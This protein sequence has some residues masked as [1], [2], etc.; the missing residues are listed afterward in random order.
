[1]LERGR[2]GPKVA[3]SSPHT[4]IHSQQ[5]T[6]REKGRKGQ[7]GIKADQPQERNAQANVCCCVT[8]KSR[9]SSS[10]RMY[11]LSSRF[12]SARSVVL[13]FLTVMVSHD[14]PTYGNAPN[15]AESPGEPTAVRRILH[16]SRG[17]EI[18]NNRR[19]RTEARTRG[20][21]VSPS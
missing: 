3:S 4:T 10:M 2:G 5:P 13:P 7:A 19:Q 6:N 12:W 14:S 20:L 21:L 9:A 17:V 18:R 8:G 11:L 15:I 1:M 16:P